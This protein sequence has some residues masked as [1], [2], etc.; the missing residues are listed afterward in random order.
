MNAREAASRA[1]RTSLLPRRR[2]PRPVQHRRALRGVVAACEAATVPFV[3]LRDRWRRTAREL[4]GH[5]IDHRM[6]STD[7]GLAGSPRDAALE[8]AIRDTRGALGRQA[9]DQEATFAFER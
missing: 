3:V 2:E 9:R 8:R 1:R 6:T 5:R 7:A 4:A